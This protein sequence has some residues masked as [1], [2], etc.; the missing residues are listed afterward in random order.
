MDKEDLAYIYNGILFSHKKNEILPFAMTWMELESILLSEI[1]Q[2]KTNSIL[3]R[4]YVEFKKQT[5]K[6]KQ[7]KNKK[8]KTR[9]TLL[10]I[11]NKLMVIRGE[12]GRWGMD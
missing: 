3:F 4:P 10:T 6:N 7:R 9:N 11:D 5:N 2:R 12:F 1:S 8:V